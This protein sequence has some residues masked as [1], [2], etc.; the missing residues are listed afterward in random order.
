MKE[1]NWN[2]GYYREGGSIFYNGEVKTIKKLEIDVI[3]MGS[4]IFDR[5]QLLRITTEDGKVIESI[6]RA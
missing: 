1:I 3:Q 6:E 2:G 4:S 5:K